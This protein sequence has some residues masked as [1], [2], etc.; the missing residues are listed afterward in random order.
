MAPRLFW[1]AAALMA[2]NCTC[3]LSAQVPDRASASAIT[4]AEIG[5]WLVRKSGDTCSLTSEG[6]T[7][8]TELFI[9]QSGGKWRRLEVHFDTYVADKAETAKQIEIV[10]GAH[11]VPAVWVPG[12]NTFQLADMDD[13]FAE[14]FARGSALTLEIDGREQAR[15]SLSGSAKA[16]ASFAECVAESSGSDVSR[17]GPSIRTWD[18]PLEP[19]R[20]AEPINPGKWIA[21]PTYPLRLGEG[22]ITFR[23]GVT[24]LGRADSCDIVQSDM[25]VEYEQMTCREMVRRARFRPAT[26]ADSHPVAG[27]WI[28]SV[29]YMIPDGA[30]AERTD[31]PKGE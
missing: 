27:E 18:P 31:E 14:R 24:P 30:P 28:S 12:R 5:N 17:P 13:P 16:Y 4:Y 15:F 29:R 3:S 20:Q 19:N 2:G 10:I 26:D 23:L 11:R 8:Y 22:T 25:S 21:S 9:A 6:D 7:F 1:L